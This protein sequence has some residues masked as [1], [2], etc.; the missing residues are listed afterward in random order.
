GRKMAA[1]S[2][3]Q[4]SALQLL[5]QLLGPLRIRLVS[6]G[7]ESRLQAGCRLHQRNRAFPSCSRVVL[8]K[9]VHLF[10]SLSVSDLSAACMDGYVKQPPLRARTAA[11]SVSPELQAAFKSLEP[12][13]LLSE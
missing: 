6:C 7:G 11:C 2:H 12:R 9:S 8:L 10:L 4:P 3:C 5:G 13:P 1:E